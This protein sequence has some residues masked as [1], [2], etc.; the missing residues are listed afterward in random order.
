MSNFLAFNTLQYIWTH[1]NCRDRP[2][3]AIVRFLQWQIYKRI[4]HQP[5]DIEL[6]PGIRL[7][8]YPDSRSASAALY[9][10]LYDYH[11]MT[12]LLRYLRPDDDFI[13]I[14]ANIGIYSLLAA[15]IIQSG[16]IYS[17]EAFPKNFERLQENLALNQLTQ[18]DA[19]AIAISDQSGT[20]HLHP[21]DADSLP[22][23][24]LTP[25][26]RSLEIPAESL[27][28]LITHPTQLSLAKMDIEGAELLALKGATALLSQQQ[29]P[30][31][32]IE[33]NDLS[34]RFGHSQSD[35][36][37]FLQQYGYSLYLYD[38]DTNQ[39]TPIHPGQQPDKNVLA[40]ATAALPHVTDRLNTAR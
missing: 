25:T 3:Q 8:C 11:D 9:C 1:P 4:I 16:T 28:N 23:I 7:R 2:Y 5:K 13:D 12:F 27:D 22:F 35:V 31:W 36:A 34:Q 10:G 6:L 15:S 30:V 14:G 18:V 32:I 17:I 37:Q 40:I 29:P 39:L 21:S 24:R 19:R 33:L 38:A 26:E 20:V